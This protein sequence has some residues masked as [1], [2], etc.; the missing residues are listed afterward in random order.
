[1]RDMGCH[2]ELMCEVFSQIYNIYVSVKKLSRSKY[3]LMLLCCTVG[4][5]YAMPET[6]V[7]DRSRV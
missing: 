2:A 7:S 4:H 1:M 6:S 3:R 5:E